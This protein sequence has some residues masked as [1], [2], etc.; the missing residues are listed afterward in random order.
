LPDARSTPS[1][2]SRFDMIGALLASGGLLCLV[3]GCGQAA[4]LGWTAPLVLGLLSI[5]VVSLGAFVAHEARAAAPLLP[6]GIVRDRQ[7]GLAYLSALLAVA[8][9]FGAFLFLTYALQV[10]LGFSP[11]LA[12][13]AFLPLS[14]ASLLAGA[15]VAPRLLRRVPVRWLM[16]SGFSLAAAGMAI[17]TQLSS[18]STY[19]VD[20]LPAEIL[21]GVGIASVMMPASSLATSRVDPRAAGIASATLNSAQQIGASLGTA[22]LNT[23]AA[24]ATLA[25]SSNISRTDA[26]VHGYAVASVFAVLVLLIGAAVALAI[27]SNPTEALVRP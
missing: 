13:V 2:A 20:I 17:L 22:V 3:Y 21:I 11:F 26:L 1:A 27:P 24:A 4:R 10:G 23:L 19:F 5:A 25:V 14:A 8:G 16:G 15:I 12:G 7:R 9:M 18:T 6:L